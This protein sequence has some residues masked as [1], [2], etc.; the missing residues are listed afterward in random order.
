VQYFYLIIDFIKHNYILIN[1]NKYLLILTTSSNNIFKRL[2]LQYYI[3]VI[4]IMRGKQTW[5]ISYY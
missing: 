5:E 4:Y 1:I 2:L 3:I